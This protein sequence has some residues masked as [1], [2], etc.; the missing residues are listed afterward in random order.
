MEKVVLKATKRDITGKQVHAVRRDGK[1]PAVIYGR[2][3]DPMPIVMDAREASRALAQ[4]SSSSLVTIELDGKEF[5]ALVREKQRNFIK[6]TLLHVDFLAVDMA[7]KIRATVGI[8]FTGLSLAVKDF[9]AVLVTGLNELEIECLPGD[10]PEKVT[11]DISAL[12]KIGDSIHVRD[13]SL[14]EKIKVLT[15]VDDMVINA[16][17]PKVEEVVEPVAPA[18]AAA[19]AEPELAVE[20]GKKEEEGGEE[21]AGKKGEGK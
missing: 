12:G 10:L 14:P 5:P 11:V 13:I 9:D 2:R 18:A 19:A 8:E 4:V 20:R 21:A 1:L 7:E 16:T 6:G 15:N 17:A 3:T